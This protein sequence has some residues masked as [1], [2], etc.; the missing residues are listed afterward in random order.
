MKQE[1]AEFCH[2]P[3]GEGPQHCVGAEFALMVVKIVL[4]EIL[5][6]YK[7][8]KAPNTQVCM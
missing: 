8:A 6:K 1:H 7:F 5:R 3:F 2:I 4:V